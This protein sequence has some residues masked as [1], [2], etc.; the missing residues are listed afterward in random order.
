MSSKFWGTW[1]PII[2]YDHAIEKGRW[3]QEGIEACARFGI[4]PNLSEREAYSKTE[5]VEHFNYQLSGGEQ[6]ALR[7][8]VFDRFRS[9]S[10][11]E[12]IACAATLTKKFPANLINWLI[13]R[14]AWLC[15]N[16]FLL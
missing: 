11:L 16:N 13:M 9:G 1:E 8:T 4:I 5:L 6:A 14:V 2:R 12:G 15:Q 3:K 7:K 10:H